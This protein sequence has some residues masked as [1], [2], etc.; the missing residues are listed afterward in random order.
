[1][2][3]VFCFV[4]CLMATGAFFFTARQAAGHDA[5]LSIHGK[6]VVI[7]AGHGGID[8]GVT[9][10]NGHNERDINLQ[11]ALLLADMLEKA[12]AQVILTRTDEGSQKE[13]K[14]KDLQKR[15]AIAN[16]NDADIFVSIHCNAYAGNS[17]WRGAQTF[18]AKNNK[19]SRLLAVNI[20]AEFCAQL[21]NT[22]RKA[23][24]HETAYILQHLTMPAVIAEVGFL[25]N[26]EEARLL[27]TPEY[28]RR[29]AW[30]ICRGIAGYFREADSGP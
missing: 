2:A 30:A 12:G 26:H 21:K 4:L 6:T 1:M 20:Q 18:F 24:P 29:V 10:I 14:L 25:S 11:I 9:G 15:I 17:R 28:Q 5:L 23:A 22:T 27:I 16:E 13:G 7:D 3:A 8:N 19:A